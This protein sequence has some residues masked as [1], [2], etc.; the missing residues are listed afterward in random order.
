MIP[1]EERRRPGWPHALVFLVAH[2]AAVAPATAADV[3]AGKDRAATACAVCHGA[4]GISMRPDAPNLAGQPAIY[5]AEQL[6]KYQ[7]PQ[8]QHEIM[9]IIARTLSEADIEN[10]AA[11]YASIVVEA[12]EPR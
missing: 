9:S 5:L 10:V 6:R 3:K 8:R 2:L 11:W 4:I 12:R 7:G 1:G